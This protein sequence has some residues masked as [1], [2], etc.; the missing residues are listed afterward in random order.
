[1][2]PK[3]TAPAKRVYKPRKPKVIEVEPVPKI[4]WRK[5]IT[6]A[7]MKWAI[8]GLMLLV[9]VAFYFANCRKARVITK[10]DKEISKDKEEISRIKRNMDSVAA[11]NAR[12]EEAFDKIYGEANAAT[13]D[14]IE[15]EVRAEKQTREIKNKTD[16]VIKKIKDPGLTSG[17]RLRIIREQLQHRADRASSNELP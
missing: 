3:K 1:M 17:D 6:P 14:R 9:G 10:N 12:L 7:N 11:V 15:T 16:E 8:V 13:I 4:N 5:W 2:S